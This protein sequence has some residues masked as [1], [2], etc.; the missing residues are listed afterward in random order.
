[1]S[2]IRFR[3][4]LPGAGSAARQSEAESAAPLRAVRIRAGSAARMAEEAKR[5]E[6][7]GEDPAPAAPARRAAVGFSLRAEGGRITAAPISKAP[8]APPAI[9][10]TEAAKTAPVPPSLP[11]AAP[12]Q[13]ADS[14]EHAEVRL[15]AKIYAML[16]RF[17]PR[18]ILGNPPQ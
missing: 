6:A 18:S 10:S 4:G 7:R 3:T 11:H 14:E 5:A 12:T 17:R 1:M 13:T 16:R 9:D 8:P 15:G 2:E